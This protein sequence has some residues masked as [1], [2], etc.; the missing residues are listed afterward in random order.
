MQMSQPSITSIERK[1]V[2]EAMRLS[3]IGVGP[4]IE[5]FERLWSGVNHKDY[6]VACNSGTNA[7]YLALKALGVGP[8]DEVIVPEYTMIATAWAVSYTGAT[9]VF[10]DCEDDLL[11]HDWKITAKTKAV[12]T[13]PIY[14]RKAP[15]PEGIP[16]IPVIEDMAE[17]HGIPPQGD[18]ACYSFYGNKIL[19]TG[20]GGMCITDNQEWAEEMRKL[21]NMYFDDGRTMIHPK[22]GHNFRM[23]NLQAAVG[24]GQVLRFFEIRDK[25]KKIEDW[26]D[27]LT[28]EDMRM[29]RR[30]ALWM[31]DIDAGNR[32]EEL[33]V[34]LESK[35]IPSRYGFKP[36]S[37]QP[38][39][40]GEYLDLNAYTWSKRI[41]YLPTWTDMTYEDVKHVCQTIRY[42]A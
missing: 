11:V 35:G 30:D 13:V 12:I 3:D 33:K 38:Q 42:F 14:G 28:P 15:I 19:T 2:D 32:Q 6:G 16:G 41:L 31:Y 29:P 37:M 17:A 21:A 9:P 27:A 24:V 26:Y 4:F 22:Q 25:R 20:E 39:Y 5:Q 18:I 23:T 34:F 36:M 8:G 7:I 40:L 1:F 10:V